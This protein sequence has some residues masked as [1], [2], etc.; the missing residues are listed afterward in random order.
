[1][2]RNGAGKSTL[3]DIVAGL[4]QPTERHCATRRSPGSPSGIRGAREARG[5]LAADACGPI[6]R[7]RRR[8]GA[9]G[10]LPAH[11]PVVRVRRGSA[12]VERAMRRTRL[13]GLPRRADA[14]AERRRAAARA[15]GRLP[16]AGSRRCCCSTSRRR[17]STSISSCTASALLREE[18][19]RGAACLAVT[20]DLNLALASPRASSC[21]R[22]A[23]WRSTFRSRRPR[24][25]RL[26]ALLFSPRLTC[27]AP[28]GRPWVSYSVTAD[29]DHAGRWVA[30]F[31][32]VF[33]TRGAAAAVRRSVRAR[34]SSVWRAPGSRLVDSRAARVSRTLLACLPAAR[35]RWRA[36]SFRR[37]CGT[38][39]RR[40]TRLASP[41]ARRWAPSW[42]SGSAGSSRRRPRASGR[43]RSPARRSCCSRCRRRAVSSARCRRSA[44]CCRH[45]HQQRVLRAHHRRAR[46]GQRRSQSF[47]ISRWL[48]GRLDSVDYAALV[49]FVVGRRRGSRSWSCVRPR[50]GT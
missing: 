44:C 19:E 20:H 48:I 26:A 35:S 43:R 40:R 47:S 15:S 4:R 8:A 5:A 34:A 14:D 11:R 17:T 41:P 28:S 32:A 24:A 7:S 27:R 42:R 21:S 31:A 1:M 12:A 25:R 50:R 38:R 46:P 36:R 29:R 10:P 22:K 16:R 9:D 49:G 3:L 45:R 13:L 2:G 6:C 33:C 39:W 37:C 30:V 23:A 18:G